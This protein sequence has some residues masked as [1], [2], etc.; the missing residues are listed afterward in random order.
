MKRKF[1]ELMMTCRRK[2][3]G[4]G[5]TRITLLSHCSYTFCYDAGTLVTSTRG[6]NTLLA[7]A[8]AACG[9]AGVR[10]FG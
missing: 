10:T 8:V 2:G 4:E 5:G 1:G 9:R 6:T 7:A 3:G